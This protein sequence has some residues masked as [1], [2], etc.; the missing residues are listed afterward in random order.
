MKKKIIKYRKETIKRT[1][2]PGD[3]IKITSNETI[4]IIIITKKIKLI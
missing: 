3:E 1:L 4:E 2:L